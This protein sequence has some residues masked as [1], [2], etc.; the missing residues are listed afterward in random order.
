M[1]GNVPIDAILESVV[2][3]QAIRRFLVEEDGLDG[4]VLV[5]FTIFAPIFLIMSIYVMDFGLLF[6]NKLEM[7]TAAQ[8]GAQWA[9]A[10]GL[11][12]N[13]DIT[14]A[15]ENAT[16]LLP[17]KITV[18]ATEFCG[19]PSLLSKTG[20]V[21]PDL[22][23]PPDA[24]TNPAPTICTAGAPCK[25]S[26]VPPGNYVSVCAKP[27]PPFQSVAFGFFSVAP[28]VEATATVRIQ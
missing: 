5:E 2:I 9:I 6:F 14:K 27:N 28:T 19:C 24:C 8:A 21:L 12:N 18:T 23:S 7:Q 11:Y 10:N 1:N 22:T 20:V 25:G 3:R 16:K 26:V 4:A 13:N 15:A 17:T